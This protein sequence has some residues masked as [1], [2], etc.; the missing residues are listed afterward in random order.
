MASKLT[1][2][3]KVRMSD[4]LYESVKARAERLG[5]SRVEYIRLV[6][7]LPIVMDIGGPKAAR[8]A[9]KFKR[10]QNFLSGS[11][12]ARD[13]GLASDVSD[14]NVST[15]SKGPESTVDSVPKPIDSPS[16][17]GTV[18]TAY[19]P[20]E[21]VAEALA[22]LEYCVHAGFVPQ[23]QPRNLGRPAADENADRYAIEPIKFIY[24]T[25]DEARDLTIAIGRWGTNLNQSTRALNTIA[26]VVCEQNI[27]DDELNQ[28][29]LASINDVDELL[30]AT[31]E[32]VSEIIQMMSQLLSSRQAAGDIYWRSKR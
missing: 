22:K 17:S 27:E 7:S 30:N 11:D 29:I 18:V 21:G 9:T 5:M 10:E 26:K 12:E 8:R 28:Y 24:I 23:F 14:G 15:G 3:L 20:S 25:D 31:I 16:K 1:S 4:E 13:S 2:E 32:G 6:L 19:T